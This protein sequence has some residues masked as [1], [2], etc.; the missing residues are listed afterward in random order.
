VTS[1]ILASCLS[2][3]QGAFCTGVAQQCSC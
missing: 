2:C 3:P 1:A